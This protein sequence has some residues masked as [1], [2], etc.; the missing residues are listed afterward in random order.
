MYL[1]PLVKRSWVKASS[2][3]LG[4][5][6]GKLDKVEPECIELVNCQ[7]ISLHVF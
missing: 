7:Q 3:S 4:G 2:G 1:Y 5:G 6:G